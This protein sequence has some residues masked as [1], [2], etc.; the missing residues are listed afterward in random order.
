M[1]QE[2]RSLLSLAVLPGR[3]TVEVAATILGFTPEAVY[4]LVKVKKLR[5]LG[6]PRPGAQKYFASGEIMRL[7]ADTQ[8]LSQATDLVCDNHAAKNAKGS[9]ISAGSSLA[10][11]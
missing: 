11:G 4:H 2:T 10:V 3:V 1:N 5:P 8:W 9:R 6:R 7:R